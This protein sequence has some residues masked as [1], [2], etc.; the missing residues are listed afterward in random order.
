M[1]SLFLKQNLN[2]VEKLKGIVPEVY[3]VG[4][5]VKPEPDLMVDAMAAGVKVGHEV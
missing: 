1:P 4:S 5:C 2:M 3:T